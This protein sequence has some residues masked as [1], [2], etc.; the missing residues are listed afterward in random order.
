MAHT[1]KRQERCYQRYQNSGAVCM[2]AVL[3]NIA[4]KEW[5]ATTQ[6]MFHL[7]VGAGVAEFPN[8]VAFLS[9]L[10][11]HEVASLDGEIAYWTSFG[12]TKFV[13]QYSNQYQNG[14]EEVIFIRNAL[15]LDTTLHIKTICTTTR[16]T[17]WI[18]AYLYSGLQ[19]D[20]S[21]LDGN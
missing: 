3:R 9:Y 7:R 17:I 6:G 10:E 14:I 16:G 20:F 13:L 4:F 19:S 11:S 21:T 18:T 5:K 12:I 8:G 15:G 2:E 1:R